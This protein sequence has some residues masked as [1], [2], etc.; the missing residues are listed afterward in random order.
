[1][2]I[3]V[4]MRTERGVLLDFFSSSTRTLHRRSTQETLAT[5]K[6]TRVLLPPYVV[7]LVEANILGPISDMALG[8]LS[9]HEQTSILARLTN[10][11]TPSFCCFCNLYIVIIALQYAQ[12]RQSCKRYRR[13]VHAN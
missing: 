3:P 5:R 8:H 11:H 12:K 7:R 6:A 13:V 10:A 4:F 1:M 9:P 2:G